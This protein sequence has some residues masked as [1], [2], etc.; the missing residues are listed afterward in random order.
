MTT[1]R[2]HASFLHVAT[3]QVKN[4]PDALHARLRARAE[5]EGTTLSELVTRLLRRELAMP[6]MRHWLTDLETAPEHG[7]LD[8]VRAVD[9]AR[10]DR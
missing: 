7:Q 6:S 9:A 5:E 1:C 3:L 2:W 4:L 10:D 8:T